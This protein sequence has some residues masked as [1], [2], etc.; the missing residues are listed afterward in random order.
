MDFQDSVFVEL[1]NHNEEYFRAR[2]ADH[3]SSWGISYWLHLVL[4]GEKEATL[5]KFAESKPAI[6][7]LCGLE[8]FNLLLE[9]NIE[10]LL[11]GQILRILRIEQVPGTRV[12]CLDSSS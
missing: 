12:W 2:F 11:I 9:K 3:Y 10:I 1:S 8:L 6:L 5:K 7:V 4:I